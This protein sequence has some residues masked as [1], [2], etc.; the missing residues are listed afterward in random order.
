[1]RPPQHSAEEMAA[2]LRERIRHET[3]VL[4]DIE[5]AWARRAEQFDAGPQPL[6]PRQIDDWTYRG[7][8]HAANTRARRAQISAYRTALQYLTGEVWS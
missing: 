5:A 7:N 6:T 4:A 8:E 2:W 3:D 1:M